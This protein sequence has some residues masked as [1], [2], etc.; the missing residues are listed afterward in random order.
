M[1]A[2]LWIFKNHLTVYFKWVNFVVCELNLNKGFFFNKG[3]KIFL[4]WIFNVVER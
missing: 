2:Q 1:T 3:L 4:V